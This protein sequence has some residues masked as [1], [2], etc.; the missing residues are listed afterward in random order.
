MPVLNDNDLIRLFLPIIQQGLVTDGFTNVITQ[1][2][3]QPT[4]QGINTLPTVFFFKVG[5]KRYGF[6]GR[7]DTWDP[8]HNIMVHTET[9]IYETTFQVNALV[10]QYPHNPYGYTASDLVNEVASIMQSDNTRAILLQDNVMILRITDIR[11]PYFVDDRDQ[12]EAIPSFDF[13]LTYPQTRTSQD[14]I[15]S[16]ERLIINSV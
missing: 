6:L 11:N 4:M 13:T 14:P 8:V 2:S 12:F 5:N 16:S 9:Q 7:Q 15:I 1:Q 10:L 3:N